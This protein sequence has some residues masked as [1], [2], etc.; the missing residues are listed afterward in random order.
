M[1]RRIAFAMF[2]IAAL[3]FIGWPSEDAPA[4]EARDEFEPPS[5]GHASA[6]QHSTPAAASDDEAA[7]NEAP[8]DETTSARRALQAA[9]AQAL[10]QSFEEPP[11]LPMPYVAQGVRQLR[12]LIMECFDL[13][14]SAGEDVHHASVAFEVLGDPEVGGIVTTA[15]IVGTA[16]PPPILSECIRETIYTLDMPP[17][18]SPGQLRAVFSFGVGPSAP[19]QTPSK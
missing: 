10:E 16:E 1:N 8:T 4:D 9:I 2:C 6:P 3:L 19:S 7:P 13:A 15:D 5:A 18:E 17:P 11:P 12:P 14:Q